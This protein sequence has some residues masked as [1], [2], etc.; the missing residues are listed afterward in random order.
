MPGPDDGLGGG[1][2]VAGMPGVP[3]LWVGVDLVLVPPLIGTLVRGAGVGAVVRG[4]HFGI[5]W[6][7]TITLE[8]K[9]GVQWS[10]SA[11]SLRLRHVVGAYNDRLIL[12]LHL[13]HA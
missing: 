3:R 1:G 11:M 12:Y 9:S 2:V 13:G 4:S 6:C 10:L 8:I 7:V 5:T